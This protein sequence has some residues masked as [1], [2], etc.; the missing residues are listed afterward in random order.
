MT[1][2]VLNNSAVLRASVK[3][4]KESTRAS[5]DGRQSLFRKREE[6]ENKIPYPEATRIQAAVADP[7]F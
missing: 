4:Q 5:H 3:N 7:D 2:R 6:Q 1:S